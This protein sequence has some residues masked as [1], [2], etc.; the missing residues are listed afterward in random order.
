ML[1]LEKSTLTLP[2]PEE[3]YLDIPQLRSQYE[4]VMQSRKSIEAI[5]NGLDKR[6]L[7]IVGPC[8]VHDP[9]S[10]LEYAERFKHLAKQVEEKFFM[11]LRTYFEKPRTT[12]GW[13]GYLLDPHLD[14]SYDIAKGVRDV[15][16]MLSD[17]TEMEIPVGSEILEML[18]FPY[19]SD[20]LSWACIGARTC[21]SPPHRQLAATLPFPV[22]FKN[23]VDG[24]LD[25]AI[26]GIVSANSS[27]LYLGMGPTG[28]V[29]RLYGEGNPS[30]H[31]VLRGSEHRPNYFPKDI[32]KATQ[33]CYRNEVCHKVVVDCSHDNCFKEHQKQIPVFQSVIEQRKSNPDIAGAMLESHLFSGNQPLSS[34]L[35]Y[36]ISVTDPCLDWPTTQKLILQAFDDL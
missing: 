7:L 3:L 4:F 1:T 24:N 9:N 11:V 27:H 33:K 13:K 28:Q 12:I 2:T 14:G 25:V 32:A 35:E 16:Q 34:N 20:Y 29:V 26:Q 18:P 17:I 10:L 15:R 5:L 23:S 31:I 30:A 22:G 21:S 36:G 19:Y 6:M 8:S